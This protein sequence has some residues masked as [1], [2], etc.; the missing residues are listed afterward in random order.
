MAQSYLTKAQ[1][2]VRL[3]NAVAAAGG[4]VAFA[5]QHR[6]SAGYVSEVR[7][8]K[9]PAGTELLA[10][11]GLMRVEVYAETR[12]GSNGGPP[13]HDASTLAQREGQPHV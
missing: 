3:I 11:I 13:L 4:V 8:G 5:A 9:K 6:M 10:A 2:H 7:S 1:V 12:R